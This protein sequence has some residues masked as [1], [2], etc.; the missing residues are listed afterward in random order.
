[1][2][3]ED[4]QQWVFVYRFLIQNGVPGGRIRAQVSQAG[5][6]SGEQFVRE[7]YPKEVTEYRRRATSLN[8]ALVVVQ[9]C[10][11]STVAQ[12]R[13]RLE[14]AVGRREDERIAI[15]LPRRNIETWIRFLT[16][17]AVVDEQVRYPKL[18][19]ESECHD[20]VDRLAAKPE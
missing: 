20:A 19:R 12:T 1:M 13:A 5:R 11:N 3:C 18:R 4:R 9:D 6:G 8:V 17:R 2:L 15:L 14:T 16:D 10:D 7:Q